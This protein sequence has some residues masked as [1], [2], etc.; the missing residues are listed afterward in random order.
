MNTQPRHSLRSRHVGDPG[1]RRLILA[2]ATM[3]LL[4][5]CGGTQQQA[6]VNRLPDATLQ[7]LTSA[8]K[9]TDLRDLRGPMVV[10][11]WANWCRP[12]RREMPI[13]QKFH[14]AHPGVKV[15]GINWRDPARDKALAV[16]RQTRVTY[17]L[18]VDTGDVVPG[19]ALP[20][21]ILLDAKGRIAYQAYV[22]I[23]SRK[24]LEDLVHTHLGAGL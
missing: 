22:E 20:K 18:V 21:L 13:Y 10:N 24:Q 17:P 15:L 23:K 1:I 5:G 6:T 14:T 4:A 9:P 2:L 11:L 19:R 8:T 7:G 12:C 3:L 16:A